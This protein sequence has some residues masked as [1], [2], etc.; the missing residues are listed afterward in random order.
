MTRINGFLAA[1]AALMIGAGAALSQGTTAPSTPAA[2]RA[3]AAT[4]ATPS[5]PTATP[6]TRAT[7]RAARRAAK[8]TKTPPNPRSA[9][10]IQCSADATAQGVKGRSAR[11]AFLRK[12]NKAA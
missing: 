1:A 7:K 6:S 12:C 4:T 11:R 9:K 5:T 3:P 10:S 2:P 8:G